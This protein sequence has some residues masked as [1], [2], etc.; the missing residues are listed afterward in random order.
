MIWKIISI[1]DLYQDGYEAL[2]IGTGVWRPN[3]L[4]IKGESLG[5]VHF[6]IDY[7]KNP[8]VYQLGERVCVIGA[9]NVAM[10]AARTAI[11]NGARQ[12]YILYRQGREDMTARQNEIQFAEIDGVHFE[13]YK[14]PLEFTHQGV[15]YLETKRVEV[16]TEQ[17]ASTGDCR[18][19]RIHKGNSVSVAVTP[20]P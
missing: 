14:T 19:R 3:R 1:D 16:E 6:A 18:A 8:A 7:L 4:R 5:H 2:F 20:L 15:R 11:R 9:G 13:F 12:V 17:G 10:D